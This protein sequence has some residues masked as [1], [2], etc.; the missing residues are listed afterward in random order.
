MKLLVLEDLEGNN[1]HTI[2]YK[3]AQSIGVEESCKLS[4]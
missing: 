2:G 1:V 4:P 3:N